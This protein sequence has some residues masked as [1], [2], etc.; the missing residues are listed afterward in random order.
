NGK[1]KTCLTFRAA[2]RGCERA[3]PL[4][5][6][7]LM[8]RWSRILAAFAATVMISSTVYAQGSI[9]GVIKDPSGA[10]LPGVTVEAAS[11]ALIEKVRLAQ[12][13]AVL[14]P[15]VTIQGGVPPNGMTPQDVG[16]SSGNTVARLTV[17]G[18]RGYDQRLFL[19]GLSVMLSAGVHN[20][21]YV[22]NMGSTQEV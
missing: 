8:S 16:G 21:P 15:G 14:L 12:N 13:L 5:M 22:A 17:H 20:T 9:T 11:P 3:T 1:R 4:L 6:E 2:D 19:N 7:G 18:S 10:V